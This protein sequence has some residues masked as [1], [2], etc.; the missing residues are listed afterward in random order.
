MRTTIAILISLTSLLACSQSEGSRVILGNEK[1]EEILQ[2]VDGKRVAVVG[3]HTSVI[4]A[5]LVENPTHLIDTLISRGVNI[6]KAFAPEHGFRGNKANG[7]QIVDGVDTATGLH[8]YSLHGKHRKPSDEHLEDV[9]VVIFDIQ[10]VGARFYTYLSTLLLVMEAA[11]ENDVNVIVLDRPTPHAHQVQGPMLNPNFSSFVGLAPVPVVHG[12]TLGEIALMANGEGWLEGGLKANLV[13]IN[14]EG[15]THSTKY[16]LPIAP[17]PN[18]PSDQSIA[19]YPSLCFL[20]PTAVSIGRGTPTPFEIVGF[21]GNTQGEFEFTP[22]PTPGASPNPKHKNQLCRGD[23]LSNTQTT[24]DLKFLVG[25]ANM[26]RND[27]GNLEGFFTSTSFFDKLAGTDKL[28]LSLEEG[29]SAKEIEAGWVD[30]INE[31][32]IA[33]TPYLLYPL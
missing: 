1:M 2:Q 10:D 18:L 16:S 14:C 20:E 5:D 22:V 6:V 4:Q 29:L 26:F 21:P 3:N 33:R 27:Q 32:K 24:W 30:D 13:V 17:S 31:F 7:A 11:A 28:R 12:M 15:Y 19:L 23:N 8:I 25:Y 9:D